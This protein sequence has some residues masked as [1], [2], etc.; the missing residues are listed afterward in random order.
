M[1]ILYATHFHT[2]THTDTM[3]GVTHDNLLRGACETCL[4]DFAF[5]LL[6]ALRLFCL[7]FYFYD[8]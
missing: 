3:C 8:W 6:R 1:C 2:H 7:Y 4:F 5:R